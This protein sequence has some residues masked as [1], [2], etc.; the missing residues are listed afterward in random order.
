MR[1]IGY[2][3]YLR[4]LAVCLCI[5]GGRG[6]LAANE[7]TELLSTEVEEGIKQLVVMVRGQIRGELTNGAGI[8]FGTRGDRLYIA[9][10][11]HVVRWGKDQA[12]SI[13]VELRGI[14]GEP[15]EAKLLNPHSGRDQLD[16]AVLSV[17]GVKSEAIPLDLI[18]FD[19]LGDATRA[20]RGDAVYSVGYPQGKAW[21]V[22]V[23]PDRITRTVGDLIRYES[24]VIEPGYSGGGLFN[25][26][27]KLVG[28]IRTDE[29][30]EG[31]AVKI[32]RILAAVSQWGFPVNLQLAAGESE[33][34][35]TATPADEAGRD[36]VYI[37]ELL[38]AC[39]AHFSAQ[40]LSTPAKNNAFEC[41]SEVLQLDRD[42]RQALEGLQR[43]TTTYASWTRSALVKKNFAVAASYLER[44]KKIAP[45]DPQVWQLREELKAVEGKDVAEQ[46]RKQRERERLQAE[47]EQRRQRE[48][49]ARRQA[50]LEARRKADEERRRQADEQKRQEEARRS[51]GD[52]AL[53][54]SNGAAI[55]KIV[56]KE[57]KRFASKSLNM[58]TPDEAEN[59]A[60]IPV[61]LEVKS[62]VPGRFWLFAEQNDDPVVASLS[63]HAVLGSYR[64]STRINTCRSGYIYGM[65]VPDQG[66]PLAMRRSVSVRKGGNCRPVSGKGP[67]IQGDIK[68]RAKKGTFKLLL[69]SPMTR[70]AYIRTVEIFGDGRPVA[71]LTASPMMSKNPYL[72]GNYPQVKSLTIELKGSDGSRKSQNQ[73]VN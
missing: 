11:N 70:N 57:Y 12:E 50:D 66:E 14:P 63:Y 67:A 24:N 6:T 40:R 34:E 4:W 43:L 3:V 30:P 17:R 18:P 31:E 51:S 9:T 10:A 19:R 26:R 28:M 54:G 72:S 15:L 27:G 32:N 5:L 42:N 48:L 65:F 59:G 33:R 73:S 68:S 2:K 38:R 55:F 16:L 71:T 1:S 44:L 36:T 56:S 7:P 53:R 60:V 64:F 29:P 13:T 21:R 49:E 25:T 62:K 22:N 45:E 35:E 37:A 20:E 69:Q 61:T 52:V 23:N 58:K 39:E 41:F 47:A 46:E 8:I